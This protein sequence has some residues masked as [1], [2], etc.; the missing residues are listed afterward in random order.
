[1]TDVSLD[2]GPQRVR[3]RKYTRRTHC[4]LWL[5]IRGSTQPE[6][7]NSRVLA[8]LQSYQDADP[9]SNPGG[10]RS[11]QLAPP[12]RF[13]DPGA[14]Q[15]QAVNRCQGSNCPCVDPN[16]RNSGQSCLP[17]L[18]NSEEEVP[19]PSPKWHFALCEARNRENINLPCIQ[20]QRQ[21]TAPH[22]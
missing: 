13:P 5:S 21:D 20:I 18:R 1:M 6:I 11:T 22:R 12:R 19:G 4:R 8:I 14:F 3:A 7:N 17:P 2:E 16:L 15:P 9:V 10:F